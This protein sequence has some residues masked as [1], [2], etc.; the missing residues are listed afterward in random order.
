MKT[1]LITLFVLTAAILN[2]QEREQ[3]NEKVAVPENIKDAFKKDFPESGAAIWELEDANF[4][5]GFKLKGMDATAV[6]DKTGHR[7]ELETAIKAE[8]LPAGVL[9]YIRKNYAVYTITETAK[10]VTDKNVVTYETE[11]GKNGN[12]MDLIFDAKGKFIDRE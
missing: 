8:E 11:V 1:I 5:A 4:E 12:F 7:K 9:E 10:I 6:Y 3:K 2:A